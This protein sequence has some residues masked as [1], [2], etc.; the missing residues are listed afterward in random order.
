MAV[1]TRKKA[2]HASVSFVHQQLCCVVGHLNL[3]ILSGRIHASAHVHRIA[4][5][6]VDWFACT[7][8]TAHQWSATAEF[9]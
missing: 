6:V 2:H 8:H 5:D 1:R 3:P 4:P 7:N 9:K